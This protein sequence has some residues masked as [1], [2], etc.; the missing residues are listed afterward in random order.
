MSSNY[1]I[2]DEVA[3]KD[4]PDKLLK[5]PRVDDKRLF[6][7]RIFIKGCM[8]EDEAHAILADKGAL[9]G[10]HQMVWID[11]FPSNTGKGG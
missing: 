3:R 1:G 7:S 5:I 10:D 11:R 9:Q 6:I 4:V 2:H 8:K